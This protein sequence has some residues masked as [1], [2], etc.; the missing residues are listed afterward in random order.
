MQAFG[1]RARASVLSGDVLEPA[2]RPASRA[3]APMRRSDVV[4]ADFEILP[5]AGGGRAAAA[6]P[7]VNDNTPFR[8]L[9]PRRSSLAAVL[10]LLQPIESMLRTMP[11]A[12]FLFA[13]AVAVTGSFYGVAGLLEASPPPPARPGLSVT[14]LRSDA[15]GTTLLTVSGTQDVRE[16]HRPARPLVAVDV[17]T[18]GRTV[19]TTR[20]EVE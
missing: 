6:P 20:L 16:T 2:R 12:V 15:T 11:A 10:R 3:A 7:V 19:S 1:T 9:P 8:P 14:T 13:V 4:D 18:G 17:I 5:V